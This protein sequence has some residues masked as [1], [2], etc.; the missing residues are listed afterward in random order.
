MSKEIQSQ[1]LGSLDRITRD[2]GTTLFGLDLAFD[3]LC[4][5]P[6]NDDC[7]DTKSF[8]D[9]IGLLYR[10][11]EDLKYLYSSYQS[12]EGSIRSDKSY[13]YSDLYCWCD[14]V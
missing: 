8:S 3:K 11:Y 4:L 6:V 10:F 13:D 1:T 9:C 12:V 2:F 7:L 5:I 14:V